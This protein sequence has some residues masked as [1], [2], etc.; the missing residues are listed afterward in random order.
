MSK[1]EDFLERIIN[2]SDIRKLSKEVKKV[3]E[4]EGR[5]RRLSDAQLKYKTKEFMLRFRRGES[6]ESMRAEVLAVYNQAVYRKNS[7][8]LNHFEMHPEQVMGALVLSRGDIAEMKT[9]EG[10]TLTIGAASFLRVIEGKSVHVFTANDFLV[11]Q[12][13]DEMTPIFELLGVSVGAAKYNFSQEDKV[14]ETERIAHNKAAYNADITYMTTATAAFTFLDD[15]TAKS[16]DKQVQHKKSISC[17]IDEADHNMM[18]N[19]NSPFIKSSAISLA[20]KTQLLDDTNPKH[21]KLVSDIIKEFKEG[22]HYYMDDGIP[23]MTNDGWVRLTDALKDGKLIVNSSNSVFGGINEETIPDD[24]KSVYFLGRNA[25]LAHFSPDYKINECYIVT[26]GEIKI[27]DN[28][29][30]KA[31]GSRFV[32]GMHQALE[33]KENLEIKPENE[34]SAAITLPSLLAQYEG[35]AGTT[36]TAHENRREFNEI[37]RRMVVKII[38]HKKKKRIDLPDRYFPNKYKKFEA[39][40][41]QVKK[42]QEKGQPI[43]LG[44]LTVKEAEELNVY[45]GGKGVKNLQLLTAKNSLEDEDAIIANAGKASM[46]TIATAMAGR[47][48]DIKLGGDHKRDAEWK[49]SS[50]NEEKSRI[51][52]KYSNEE[53]KV[54]ESGGLFVLGIGR[55][56]LMN[57]DEQFIGRSGRQGDEGQSQFMVSFDDDVF[58]DLPPKE[59]LKLERARLSGDNKKIAKAI[60]STQKVNVSVDSSHREHAFKVEFP[61]AMTRKWFSE[62]RGSVLQNNYPEDVMG[63]MLDAVDETFLTYFNTSEVLK[64]NFDNYSA[65][66]DP[67][68]AYYKDCGE[69]SEKFQNDL[70]EKLDSIEKGL[71]QIPKK[72]NAIGDI[73]KSIKETINHTI[74]KPGL[75]N[76]HTTPGLSH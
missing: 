68:V 30:R 49:N 75:A 56:P 38:T 74:L 24:L 2:N 41:E 37:F 63:K 31:E 13:A 59:R 33:A 16:V 20:N 27:L 58:N 15:L 45:L 7:T 35:F 28:N 6:L 21:I 26:N 50:S 36:G 61:M 34:T 3:K 60:A 9:G 53:Q 43:L 71:L 12:S 62:L 19:A 47:G 70:R 46:V 5:M 10:K 73:Q 52:E 55:S 39:I 69:L 4:L 67:Y 14:G 64:E 29:N 51:L 8:A 42:C 54:K 32:N 23:I 25:L 65:A 57:N 22:K 11:Q 17:I 18:Q 72:E 1:L 44:T 48:T 76:T 40:F 66:S